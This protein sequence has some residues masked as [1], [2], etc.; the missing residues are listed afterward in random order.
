[1]QQTAQRKLVFLALIAVTC[2]V[3][4]KADEPAASVVVVGIGEPL[5]AGEAESFLEDALEKAGVPVIDERGV[6]EADIAL[7]DRQ[8]PLT[9][10]LIEALRPLA[11][12]LVL[13]RAEYLGERPLE[14]GERFDVAHQARLTVTLIPLASEA[15]PSSLLNTRIEY[16]HLTVAQWVEKAVR[17][18]VPELLGVMA[19]DRER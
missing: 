17:P 3:V 16:A 8:G 1:M 6:P 14:G 7:G 13:I 2:S 12:Y 9:R 10:E 4:V 11:S 19:T 18:V 5:L 15:A